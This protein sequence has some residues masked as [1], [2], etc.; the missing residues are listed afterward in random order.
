MASGLNNEGVSA[1]IGSITLDCSSLQ[2]D[3]SLEVIKNIPPPLVGIIGAGIA[4][5]KASQVLLERGCN[6]IIFEA[7]DRIGGRVNTSNYLGK[8]VDL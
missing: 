8:D 3:K 4:G 1:G 5:L 2:E 6:V 7:R